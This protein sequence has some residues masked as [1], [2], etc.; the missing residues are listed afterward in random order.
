[1][2]RIAAHLLGQ[3]EVDLVHH[4]ARL[5][6]KAGKE[7]RRRRRWD[8]RHSNTGAAGGP[9]RGRRRASALSLAAWISWSTSCADQLQ[10]WAV[11]DAFVA[12]SCREAR[13]RV[14]FGFG[15]AFGCGLV[16]TLVIGERMRVG[17]DDVRVHQRRPFARAALIDG[18]AQRVVAGG[19]VRAIHLRSSRLGKPAS[20]REMLPPAVWHSTGTEM[21]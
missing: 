9:A 14:A 3:G 2:S 6:V 13:D 1:M 8:R 16:E 20:S 7:S 12:T 18:L 19:E 4:G 11:D 5:A 15:R 17:P 21:A 10:R